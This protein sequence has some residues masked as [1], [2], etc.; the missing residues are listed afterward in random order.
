MRILLSCGGTGGHIYPAISIADKI[1]EHH[2]DC[3]ILFIGTKKGME[4]S[5]VPASGYEIKGIDASGIDRRHPLNNIKTV[6]NVFRGGRE[7]AAIIDEFRPDAA[8]GT[9]GYVTGTVIMQAHRRGIPC[10]IHEQNAIPGVTNKILERFADKLFIS[11]AD[12]AGFFAHPDKCVLTGNPIRGQFSHL[13]EADCRAM[14]GLKPGEKLILLFGG[15]LG[16]EML[17]EACIKLI[18]EM[19]DP[20]IKLYFI[21]GKRYYDS[22]AERLAGYKDKA[23]MFTVVP[24]ADNMPVLMK[25]A[26]LIVSRAGAIAVCEILACGKP[27]VLIPS[28]NVTNNH[29]YHNARAVADAG[30]ALLMEESALEADPGMFPDRVLKLMK[31]E[32]ALSS[33]SDAARRIAIND[34]ADKIY[35]NLRL[36]K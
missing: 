7:A 27:S 32:A 3:E 23:S 8:I 17:N 4:N 13:N 10:Y 16:A 5:L 20:D 28:P 9:G 2:P 33:M 1:R 24:Y 6:N 14:L 19:D 31:D 21:T 18:D 30:A 35:E 26:D 34:A 15:S 12:S 22:V 25:A 11:F 29:Q 36:D